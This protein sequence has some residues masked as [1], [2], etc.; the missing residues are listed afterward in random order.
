M[1]NVDADTDAVGVAV[2]G[3][4]QIAKGEDPEVMLSWSLAERCVRLR[5]YV[6]HPEG[7]GDGPVGIVLDHDPAIFRSPTRSEAKSD[8]TLRRYT[9]SSSSSSSSRRRRR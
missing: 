1:V 6:R 9:S 2:E 4:R 3:V 5:P 8:K 7:E